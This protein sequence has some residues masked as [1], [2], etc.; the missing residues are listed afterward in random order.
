MKYNLLFDVD[1][2]KASHYLQYPENTE[3][4]FSYIEARGGKYKDTVFFGLQYFIKQY[5]LTPITRQDVELAKNLY[6]AHG[7]PFN[8]EGWLYIAEKLNGFLPIKIKAVPEGMK[9]AKGNILLSVESTDPNVPWITS[10]VET[11]LLRTIW[12]ATTVAT[13][14]N[15]IKSLIK[16]GLNKS[17]DS[18]DELS[19]KLHDFGSRGTSSQESALIGGMAHLLNFKGTD[20]FVALLAARDYYHCDMAGFS[21]PASEHSSITSWGKENE[22]DAYR[23]MITQFGKPG[24]IYA[25]VS[26]SYDIY[27]AI[28]NIWGT[29]LKQEVIDSNATL[30]IRV[31]IY[32]LKDINYLFVTGTLSSCP[33]LSYKPSC[34]Q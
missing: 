26:D 20:T 11:S 33:F 15:F 28:S 4:V 19:F 16:D 25:C 14:S 9:V 17:S 5:L 8:Y 31:I 29:L 13:K 10:W 1:S 23:N 12:Y 34:F 30:V 32:I 27:N 6:L 24:A 18:L 3:S 7:L 21:I 2:Y 22:V